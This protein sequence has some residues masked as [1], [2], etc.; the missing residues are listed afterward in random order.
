[1]SDSQKN[2]HNKILGKKG[3]KAALKYLK[4]LKYKILE[5]NYTCFFGEADIIAKDKDDFVF[6]EVKTRESDIFGAPSE[7]VSE[8]RQRRYRQI[9]GYYLRNAE[10][11]YIRFD[12]I[13][14]LNGK[15]NHI[16]NAF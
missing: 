10:N 8:Q 6:I 11:S 1:M 12:V 15:I 9:A 2:L 5:K 16:K 4:K 13:E 3:E 14:I 7:A